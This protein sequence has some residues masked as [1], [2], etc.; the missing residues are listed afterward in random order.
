M[1][2]NITPEMIALQ[3]TMLLNND[4]KFAAYMQQRNQQNA[5]EAQMLLAVA[6]IYAIW[7]ANK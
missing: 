4:E 1:T 2:K 7:K 6:S 3:A 5:E